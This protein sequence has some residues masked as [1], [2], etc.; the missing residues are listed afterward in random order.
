MDSEIT[1]IQSTIIGKIWLNN[2]RGK[3]TDASFV[4]PRDMEFGKNKSFLI[5]GMSFR[6]DRN[7]NASPD[8]SA[9]NRDA[10]EPLK[11][12]KGAV[13]NFFGNDQRDGKRDPDLSVS[14]PLPIEQSEL[15]IRN[16][17]IAVELWKAEHPELETE[18]DTI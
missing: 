18:L 9:T 7:L 1:Q 17:E 15:I 2:S 14:T 11:L 8:Y 16:S 5:N 10:Y 12:P 6:T 13:L 3:I 4:L